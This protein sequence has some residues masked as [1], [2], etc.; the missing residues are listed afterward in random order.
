MKKQ[1]D[2]SMTVASSKAG[3]STLP[4]VS[5]AANKVALKKQAIVEDSANWEEHYDSILGKL[6]VNTQTN[7]QIT[8]VE[9][10]Q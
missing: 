4:Q 9:L 2:P 10:I 3:F 6:W 1:H 8:E 7:Q 5:K